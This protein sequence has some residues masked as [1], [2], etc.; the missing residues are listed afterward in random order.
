MTTAEVLTTTPISKNSIVIF[1]F[2]RAE[3]LR[4]CINSVLNAEGS[5]DWNRVIV[6]QLGHSDVQEVV[7]EFSDQFD[8]VLKLK[9]Q[10]E[11]TL[12]NINFNRVFGMSVCFDLFESEVVLGIEEDTVIAFDA[13][14]FINEMF[15]IY[16]SRRAFRGINLG[17]LEVKTEDN[18]YSYSLLRFGLHGQAGALT[19][20]TWEKL[21]LEELLSD[22]SAEGWDS[23]IEYRLKSGFMVTPN[24]SRL[25]DRGWN[26]TYAPSDSKHPYF[27]NQRLSWI[28]NQRIPRMKYTRI[29][30]QHSWR[31]DAINYR[32]SHSVLFYIR[33]TG[34]GYKIFLWW[35]RIRFPKFSFTNHR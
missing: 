28:G 21:S 22:I 15:H 30:Q 33:S 25:L 7:S 12:G 10:K 5:A 13:L 2:S 9:K 26:G 16:K 35:K 6:H 19:K 24:A 29:D 3:L 20:R 17:S 4:E 32:R 23:K 1:A 14:C 11:D 18:L 34:L 31:S 27:E 8:L